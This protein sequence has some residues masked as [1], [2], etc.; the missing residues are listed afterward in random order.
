LPPLACSKSNSRSVAATCSEPLKLSPVAA[1]LTATQPPDFGLIAAAVFTS[2]H[3]G[4]EPDA[5][6]H[7]FQV[8]SVIPTF[9]STAASTTIATVAFADLKTT[10]V[11]FVYLDTATVAFANHEITTVASADLDNATVASADHET[12]TVASADLESTTVAFVDLDTAAITSA[13]YM[14]SSNLRSQAASTSVNHHPIAQSI[15]SLRSQTERQSDSRTS[16]YL[17]LKK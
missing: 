11:A 16:R 13:S 17:K 9:A 12:T 5:L 15:R 4:C 8:I 3:S 1:S 6:V 14:P 7:A 10:A 2:R